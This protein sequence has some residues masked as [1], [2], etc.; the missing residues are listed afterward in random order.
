MELTIDWAEV[1]ALAAAYIE[2]T[3]P[4]AKVEDKKSEGS[5]VE[6]K[7]AIKPPEKSKT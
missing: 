1:E 3:K 5:K 4:A 6:V 7:P 2:R